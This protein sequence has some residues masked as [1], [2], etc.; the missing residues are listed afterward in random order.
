MTG[1]KYRL[2]LYWQRESIIQE[3]ILHLIASRQYRRALDEL[4]LSVFDFS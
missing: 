2:D 4:E 3:M 1:C